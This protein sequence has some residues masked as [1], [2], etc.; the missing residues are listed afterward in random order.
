MKFIK[1]IPLIVFVIIPIVLVM[2]IIFVFYESSQNL[3]RLKNGID[4]KPK[5]FSE[6]LA[7]DFA[8][9][10]DEAIQDP[11]KCDSTRVLA[12]I[13]KDS[14]NPNLADNW[15]DYDPNVHKLKI[16]DNCWRE[17]ENEYVKF[18]FR[19]LNDSLVMWKENYFGINET[20]SRSFGTLTLKKN[21]LPLYKAIIAFLELSTQDFKEIKTFI[22]PNKVNIYRAESMRH[23]YRY[24]KKISYFIDLPS[25]DNYLNIWS[26][27]DRVIKEILS[28]IETK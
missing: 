9:V 2:I 27:S 8:K 18:K 19:D 17:Y 26:S 7:T 21:K 10:G 23:T 22:N 14:S 12:E 3:A 13:K 1:K 16:L 28:T 15:M 24:E 4:L 6:L 25:N 5:P 11:S 20:N